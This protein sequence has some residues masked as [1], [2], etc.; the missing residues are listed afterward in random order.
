VLEDLKFEGAPKPKSAVAL[1]RRFFA[2]EQPDNP[3]SVSVTNLDVDRAL[4]HAKRLLRESARAFLTAEGSTIGFPKIRPG[5]HLRIGGLRAPFDGM[6]YV[7]QAVHTLDDR[8]YRTNF[9]VR[10]PGMLPPEGYQ[11][12]TP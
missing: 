3:F 9:S 1:R 11:A 8:G 6:Y 10:R 4:A 12:G 2:D 5:I 7:T